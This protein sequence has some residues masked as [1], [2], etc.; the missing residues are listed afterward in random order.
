MKI[1]TCRV[2][3]GLGNQLFSYAAARA[4][5]IRNGAHLKIDD[6][7][8]FTHDVEYK[9]SYSLSNFNIPCKKINV[10]YS[11]YKLRMLKFVSQFI[12]YGNK[13]YFEQR[14]IA[15]DPEI[16][17]MKVNRNL[18]ITGN[19]QSENY[20][21]D[22]ES[23]IRSDLEF[24]I[25][26]EIIDSAFVS[27]I[28]TFNSVAI[29]IRVFD[30]ITSNKTNNISKDYYIDAIN[31]MEQAVIE[32]HYFIFSN[33]VQAA[34]DMGIWKGKNVVFMSQQNYQ[35]EDFIDMWLM[36]QCK[37][38]IIA[39]STFSWWGAWLSKH[40]EKVIIAPKKE[41]SHGI[42]WWGFDGLLPESWIKI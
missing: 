34:I 7:S 22:F 12:K 16:V 4:M 26:A 25:P 9:R 2:A 33:D 17:K 11:R 32:P 14:F 19:W 23:V 41:I 38:F 13:Y 5:S 21:K 18:Y 42:M 29:H 20:F 6:F 27:K 31:K 3:G 30:N 39:N 28:K 40:S 36:T 8:G 24:V 15:Y 10:P 1:I 37:H 35:A